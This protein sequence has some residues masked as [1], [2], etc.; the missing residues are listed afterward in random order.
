MGMRA[1]L[2]AFG[3]SSA[4]V[5]LRPKTGLMPSVG[6]K[7]DSTL[8]QLN[9]SGSRWAR[10]QE[11]DAIS[12][13]GWEGERRRIRSKLRARVGHE[14]PSSAPLRGCPIGWDF[15]PGI[16]G[17]RSTRTFRYPGIPV[18]LGSVARLHAAFLTESRTGG[19]W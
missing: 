12:D 15:L 9:R 2:G 8:A 13:S 10:P 17:S 4:V 5:K 7:V 16:N 11:L 3:R 14:T 19:R 1:T 6:R 18:E